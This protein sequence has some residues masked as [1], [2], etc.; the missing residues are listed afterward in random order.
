MRLDTAFLWI[1]VINKLYPLVMQHLIRT[2]YHD[3]G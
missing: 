1:T 3:C 2:E